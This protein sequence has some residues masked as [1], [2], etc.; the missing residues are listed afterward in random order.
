MSD[1]AQPAQEP[2]A[3]QLLLKNFTPPAPGEGMVFRDVTYFIGPEI[4]R[5]SFGVVH[6]CRDSW[7]N[8]LAAKVPLP[9]GPMDQTINPARSDRV[10][11]SN[12]QGQRSQAKTVKL[13]VQKG[14][15][16]KPLRK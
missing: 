14:R 1:V 15:A 16:Q 13:N 8:E 2:Q 7:G 9:H 3:V 12:H 5:G 4:G 6:E 10:L 11:Y